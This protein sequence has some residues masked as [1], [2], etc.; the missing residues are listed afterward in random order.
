M[1]FVVNQRK[2]RQNSKIQYLI[3]FVFDCAVVV[4]FR[5]EIQQNRI[6]DITI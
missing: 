5:C 2:F 4:N 3:R 1:L 6:V